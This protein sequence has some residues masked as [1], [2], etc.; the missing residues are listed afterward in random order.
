MK[1]S[2]FVAMILGTIGATVIGII[3]SHVPEK[4]K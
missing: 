3:G 2:R 4:R 1:K